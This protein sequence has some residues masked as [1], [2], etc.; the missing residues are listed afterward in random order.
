MLHDVAH[1]RRSV[2]RRRPDPSAAAAMLARSRQA[3]AEQMALCST[4][5]SGH[6]PAGWFARLQA[7]AVNWARRRLVHL[8][9]G[10]IALLVAT[11]AARGIRARKAGTRRRGDR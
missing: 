8:G 11:A 3:I 10:L 9:L 2:L 6:A 7:A 1:R 4:G 5:G